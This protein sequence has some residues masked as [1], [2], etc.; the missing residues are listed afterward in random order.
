MAESLKID[1][2]DEILKALKNPPRVRI[3]VLGKGARPGSQTDNATIGAAHEFGTATLPRRSFLRVPLADNLGE[4]LENSGILDKTAITRE[5]IETGSVRGFM[6]VVAITA[7]EVVQ[8]AFATGGNGKWKQWSNPN[9]TNNTGMI[10][11]D[12]QQLRES[13]TSEVVE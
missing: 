11:L 9:Y 10:L 13:I 7:E 12:T 2:L 4:R 6:Q 1:G 5:L 3:G 8:D